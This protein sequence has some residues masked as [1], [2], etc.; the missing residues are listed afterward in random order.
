MNKHVIP[1]LIG[2][3]VLMSISVN[4]AAKEWFVAPGKSGTGTQQVPF[5]EIEAAL[6]AAQPGDTVVVRA[7]TYRE[8]VRTVRDGSDDAP[9]TIRAERGHGSVVVTTQGTVLHVDHSF[10]VVDGLVI[11][12]RYA[13]R[14]AVKVSN[15][16]QSFVMRHVE[17]RRSSRDC[18]TIGSAVDV[19]IEDS[20]IHHCL[21]PAEGRTDAHGIVAS[22]VRGL[23][24][25]NTEIHTFSGDAIQLNRQH[26]PDAPAWN[27]VLIEGCRLWL[28]PL[29]REE[30]GFA[31]G[32]VPGENAVDTKVTPGSPRARITIRDTQAWGFG[33]GLIQKQAAFNLKEDIDAT[34][35]R[36][37]VWDSEIA[38]RTRGS[39]TGPN[40]AWVRIQNAVVYDVQVGVRYEDDIA[41]LRVWNTT[42][43]LGVGRAFQEA[44]SKQR[45]LDVRN[46]AILGAALPPEAANTSNLA[47]RPEAFVNP[48]A[49]DYRLTATSPAVDVGTAIPDVATDRLGVSR[50]RG[51]GYDVGAYER[52]VSACAS[53]PDGSASR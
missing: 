6:L 31:A 43:G 48:S 42:F 27:D 11:D 32:V 21:N 16:V 41:H 52:C 9:I 33:G 4:A 28:E 47:L 7:G 5:G 20:L 2:L 30:N 26:T 24:V 40:G 17:V 46:V 15:G 8:A 39:R 19:L 51:L 13:P 38:F 50:P 12:G 10:V 35:D 1:T 18:I 25:R 49:H 34:L 37:T 53:A 22:A 14:A 45:R 3:C 36:V 29:P 23:T 44:S